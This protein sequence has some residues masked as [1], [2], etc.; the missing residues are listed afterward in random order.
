MSNGLY[1]L[2]ARPITNPIS[3]SAVVHP[4]SRTIPIDLW[5]FHLGHPSCKRLASMM[6]QYPYITINKNYICS[7]CHYSK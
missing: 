3:C 6:K 2:A 5:H 4:N 1:T 7:T